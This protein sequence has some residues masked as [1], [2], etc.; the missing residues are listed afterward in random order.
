MKTTIRVPASSANLGPGFDSLGLSLQLYLTLTVTIPHPTDSKFELTATGIDSN[1]VNLN[2]AD[3]LITTTALSIAAKYD[4][5]L[6]NSLLVCCDNEI[7][8]G[9]GLG[10]SGSA[11]VA[12]VFLA[13]V[14]CDLGLS[15]QQILQECIRIGPQSLFLT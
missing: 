8:F 11:I 4:K 10:S 3:N 2:P 15:Q 5:S 6:P 12:G 13:N 9:G 14:A 1:L 7:P